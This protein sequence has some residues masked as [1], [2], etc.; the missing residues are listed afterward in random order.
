MLWELSFTHPAPV[1]ISTSSVWY[2]FYFQIFEAWAWRWISPTCVFWKCYD[3]FVCRWWQRGALG[4][5]ILGSQMRGSWETS[6]RKGRAV[7]VLSLELLCA[8]SVAT[9]WCHTLSKAFLKCGFFLSQGALLYEWEDG[10]AE[11]WKAHHKT[12][13]SEQKP[14]PSPWHTVPTLNKLWNIE[15]KK[16]FA[17]KIPGKIMKVSLLAVRKICCLRRVFLFW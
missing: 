10:K 17:Q 4:F 7:L 9:S 14:E 1:K 2:Q 11:P 16:R 5:D 3:A 15:Q 13:V 6:P 12:R 8:K